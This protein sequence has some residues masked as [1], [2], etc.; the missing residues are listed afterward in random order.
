MRVL[1]TNRDSP[2]DAQRTPNLIQGMMQGSKGREDT[3]EVDLG[4][5]SDG[6]CLPTS[7]VMKH[8]PE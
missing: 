4:L 3:K 2:G 7:C 8:Y 5:G 1:G 6:Q